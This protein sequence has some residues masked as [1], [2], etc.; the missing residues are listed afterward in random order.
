MLL[1]V[2]SNCGAQARAACNCGAEY[3]RAGAFAAKAV[4]A[5]PD[6]SDRAIAAE[7]GVGKD[8]VRRARQGG[9]NAPT[10]KRTGKDGKSYPARKMPASKPSAWDKRVRVR[11]YQI[12]LDNSCRSGFGIVAD[13]LRNL[14]KKSIA[15][16]G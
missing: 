15:S 13:V 9:A 10:D 1:P 7:I 11:K 8:T 5:N 12:C 2:C 6:K 4:A 14:S 16:D 3:I